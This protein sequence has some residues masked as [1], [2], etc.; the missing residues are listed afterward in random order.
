MA[1]ESQVTQVT[2][3]WRLNV[4]VTT[5]QMECPLLNQSAWQ[6]NAVPVRVASMYCITSSKD[7]IFI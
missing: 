6:I 7:L 5:A 2:T 4:S 1:G 3:K